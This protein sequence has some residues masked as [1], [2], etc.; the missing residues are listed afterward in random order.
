[1]TWRECWQ[2]GLGCRQHHKY[3]YR[4]HCQLCQARPRVI[5]GKNF[6]PPTSCRNFFALFFKSHDSFV[7]A[8]APQTLDIVITALARSRMRLKI[9]ISQ[10][11]ARCLQVQGE[12][13]PEETKPPV[14][15]TNLQKL[16]ARRLRVVHSTEAAP[17]YEFR[18][19]Q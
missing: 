3:R 9:N 1:M 19:V 14:S 4:S 12:G 7:T 18:R 5:T 8:A 2:K 17:G 15:S 6:A 11:F 10:R 13:G 16:S